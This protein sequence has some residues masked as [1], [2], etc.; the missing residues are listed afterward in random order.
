MAHATAQFF[1]S[2]PPLNL[3]HKSILKILKP[4]FVCLLTI[5]RYITYKT[6]FSFC[7]LG[8]AQGVGLGGTVGGG[9]G[10]G[11]SKNLFFQIQP[12]LVCELLA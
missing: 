2:R 10:A 5:E 1:W 7:R 4:N 8:H 9:G 11:G 12:D 3:N 6:G